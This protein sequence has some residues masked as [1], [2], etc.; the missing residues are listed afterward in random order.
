MAHSCCAALVPWFAFIPVIVC[1]W[2]MTP[3]KQTAAAAAVFT[4]FT[5]NGAGWPNI[6]ATVLVGQVCWYSFGSR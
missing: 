3:E 2:A 1:L 4:N 6:G 5:D